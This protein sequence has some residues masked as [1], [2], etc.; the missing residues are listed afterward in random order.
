[1]RWHTAPIGPSLDGRNPQKVNP[2]SGGGRLLPPPPAGFL[3]VARGKGTAC[4]SSPTRSRRRV[5]PLTVSSLSTAQNLG[6]VREGIGYTQRGVRP[7]RVSRARASPPV[8]RESEHRACA[9]ASRWRSAGATMTSSR[10]TIT[11]RGLGLAREPPQLRQPACDGR[12]APQQSR[13]SAGGSPSPW[14]SAIRTSARATWPMASRS[15]WPPPPRAFRALW[16]LDSTRTPATQRGS[17]GRKYSRR[18]ALHRETDL[19]HTPR[20]GRHRALRAPERLPRVRALRPLLRRAVGRAGSDPDRLLPGQDDGRHGPLRHRR[21]AARG[22]G[23]PP[24]R[25]DGALRGRGSARAPARLDRARARRRRPGRA[26]APALRPRG[27]RRAVPHVGTRRAEG[28]VRDGALPAALL[29]GLLLLEELRPPELPLAVPRRRRG[30]RPRRD[31]APHRRPH[32]RPSVAPARAAGDRVGHPGRRLL[33]LAG[34]HRRRARPGRRLEP[35]RR[36][37]V[38][39]AAEDPGPP[40]P[41]PHLPQPRSGVLEGRHAGARLLSLTPAPPARS[42]RA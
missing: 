7:P 3:T 8:H 22:P 13:S 15:S 26:V 33:L 39:P 42:D 6:V 17:S 24:E 31:R 2:D 36:A 25:R 41:R 30:A 11:A 19:T 18:R 37:P 16:N 28:R 38:D 12:G 4:T 1:M 5:A 27:R 20:H 32:A 21:V 9:E 34:A 14:C 23:A 29:R 35:G 40:R 10:R